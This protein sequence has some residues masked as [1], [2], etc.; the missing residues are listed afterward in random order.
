MDER[1]TLLLEGL[2][3]T[4]D[5]RVFNLQIQTLIQTMSKVTESWQSQP[6]SGCMIAI[7]YSHLGLMI[8][9][10]IGKFSGGGLTYDL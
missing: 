7:A 4:I 6:F 10:T 5:D 2:W 8:T 1:S 9:N 3:G